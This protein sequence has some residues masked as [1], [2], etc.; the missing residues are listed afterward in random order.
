MNCRVQLTGKGHLAP[1]V[2]LLYATKFPNSV[3]YILSSN[4]C[5]SLNV[6]DFTSGHHDT[7]VNL[8][9]ERETSCFSDSRMKAG[10]T[11]TAVGKL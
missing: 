6:P 1:L 9:V 8:E 5:L 4:E 3:F 10:L 11:T 7:Q 2:A